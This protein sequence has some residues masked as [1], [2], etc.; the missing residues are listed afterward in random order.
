MKAFKSPKNSFKTPSNYFQ[1][2]EDSILTDAKTFDTRKGF[3]VPEN[4]FNQLE[5]KIVST[6]LPQ[7]SNLRFLWAAVSS[8][9]A[10][11]V[12]GISVYY[13][14]TDKSETHFTTH[15]STVD[16][17]VE[18]AV[19][20]SLYK[21]YFVDDEQK[22]SSNDITLDDLDDFYSEQQLSSSY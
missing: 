6:S 21:S 12:V 11:L 20:K 2:L 22:K 19:Y 5:E 4:Y 14:S 16:E 15:Q 17:H 13:V 10:C 9:A 18:D 7:P 3:V 8:V 1:K